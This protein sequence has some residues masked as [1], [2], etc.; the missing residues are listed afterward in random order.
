MNIAICAIVRTENRYLPSW[1][2]HHLNLGF[3]HFF[4]YDNARDGEEHVEDILSSDLSAKVTVFHCYNR[5]GAQVPVYTEFYNSQVAKVYDYVAFI[6]IDEF[7]VLDISKQD[8][9]SNIKEYINF[10]KNPDAIALNWMIFGDNGILYDDGRCDIERFRTPLPLT[11]SPSNLWGKQPI[12]CHV[13][14]IYKTGL[15]IKC[16]MPHCSQGNYQLVNSNGQIIEKL[17]QQPV[18]T[19]E[20]CYV[21]HFITRTIEEFLNTKIKRGSFSSRSA[22]SYN[23]AGFFT[24]NRPTLHKLL[25]YWN[26]CKQ[27]NETRKKSFIWWVKCWIKM[28]VINPFL[29]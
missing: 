26:A 17:Q 6:D 9:F 23:I 13:K 18:Y 3:D 15:G 19:F 24:Y 28:W 29:K 1:L 4:L 5:V 10:L 7:I 11:Y 16:I 27:Y 14:T 21:K 20:N 22:G 25:I 12:N 8:T 2:F